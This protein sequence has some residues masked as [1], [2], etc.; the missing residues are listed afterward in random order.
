MGRCDRLFCIIYYS[1][2]KFLPSFADKQ[3]ILRDDPSSK[4]PIIEPTFVPLSFKMDG[5]LGG[6]EKEKKF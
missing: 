4:G 6:T 2:K 3:V 1:K 5:L